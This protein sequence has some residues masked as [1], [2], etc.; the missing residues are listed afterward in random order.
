MEGER[1]VMLPK[2]SLEGN[3][4]LKLVISFCNVFGRHFAGNRRQLTI[5]VTSVGK[6]TIASYGT[7]RF[8]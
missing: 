5:T 6:T 8:M 1:R 3:D 4:K 2:N 7:S